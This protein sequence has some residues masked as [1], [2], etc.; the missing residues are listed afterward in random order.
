MLSVFYCSIGGEIPLLFVFPIPSLKQDLRNLISLLTWIMLKCEAHQNPLKKVFA[1]HQDSSN[2]RTLYVGEKIVASGSGW[3]FSA[4]FEDI[5]L[6]C[7]AL[8]LA[9]INIFPSCVL[10]QSYFQFFGLIYLG[11]DWNIGLLKE[12]DG[13]SYFFRYFWSLLKT[14]K[15]GKRDIKSWKMVI[16][17][18]Q[19]L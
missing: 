2:H 12:R 9:C 10:W 16:M 1:A 5:I 18:Q 11:R 7:N 4:G 14:M 15:K 19:V 13:I 3:C 17:Q 8:T 6:S